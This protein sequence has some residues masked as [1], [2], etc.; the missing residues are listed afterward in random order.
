[1]KEAAKMD[2][3]GVGMQGAEHPCQVLETIYS[4]IY[5]IPHQGWGHDQHGATEPPRECPGP[6]SNKLLQNCHFTKPAAFLQKHDFA[7]PRN[8]CLGNYL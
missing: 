2:Y 1:M 6:S 8:K 5:Q 4:P 3:E 7:K